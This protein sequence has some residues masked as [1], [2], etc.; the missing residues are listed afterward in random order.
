MTPSALAADAA[1]LYNHPHQHQQHQQHQQQL[2]VE[3]TSFRRYPYYVAYTEEGTVRVD[4]RKSPQLIGQ[5]S[6]RGTRGYN[7]DRAEFR[8]LRI[9]GMV[10]DWRDKSSAQLMY[11]GVYDG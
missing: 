5:T 8:P 6:S 10:P 2:A 7:Q 3:E 4:V 1:Q 11:L 9:P